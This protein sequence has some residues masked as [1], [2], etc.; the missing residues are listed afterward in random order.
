[1]LCNSTSREMPMIRLCMHAC[2]SDLD[3][4]LSRRDF[5]SSKLPLFYSPGFYL[6]RAVSPSSLAAGHDFSARYVGARYLLCVCVCAF[7]SE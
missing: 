1:M 6:W 5:T 3:R 7:L 2:S 4:F